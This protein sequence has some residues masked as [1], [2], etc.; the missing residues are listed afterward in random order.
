MGS[1][2][3]SRRTAGRSGRNTERHRTGR[4]GTLKPRS[5]LQCRVGPDLTP[6]LR[7]DARELIQDFIA[8]KRRSAGAKRLVVGLS[9]GIDSALVAKLAADAC[10]PRQVHA[11][12]LPVDLDDPHCRDARSWARK[13]GTRITVMPIRPLIEGAVRALPGNR[14]TTGNIMARLRMTILYH[15]AALDKGIVLGTGNK[16]ELALGYFTKWGD[17]GADFQPIGDLYKTQVRLLAEQVGVPVAIR[18]KTPTAGLWPGQTDEG[19]LGASY[20]NLD[21]ILVGIEGRLTDA[22]IAR[23]G[24]VPLAKVRAIRARVVANRHKR[25]PPM[26]P[27]LGLRT[28]GI[29][30]LD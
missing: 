24:K 10:G 13:L 25:V 14:M 20:E 3:D 29:D 8:S 27:K 12:L 19:D 5:P 9:G 26:I 22:E 18:R 17:G 6:T 15:H 7:A 4:G 30:W 11:L 23:H 21:R 28:I 2:S 1:T 16:T